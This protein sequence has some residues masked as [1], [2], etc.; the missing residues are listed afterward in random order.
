MFNKIFLLIALL[1]LPASVIATEQ[2]W[3]FQVYLDDKK[4]GTHDFV[5]HSKCAEHGE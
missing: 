3:R 4:I 2:E 1:A 5:L